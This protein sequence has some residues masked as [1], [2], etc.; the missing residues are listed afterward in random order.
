MHYTFL[1]TPVFWLVSMSKHPWIL[2]LILM[3]LIMN[4]F[5]ILRYTRIVA[6]LLYLTLSRP[7]ISFVVHKLS[8]F[9][10]QPRTPHLQAAHHLLRYIK[11]KPDQGLLFSASSPYNWK[12]FVMPI[13]LLVWTHANPLLVSVYSLVILL[14]PEK[15]RSRQRCLALQLKP[16]T[17]PLLPQQ[18]K[19][20]GL[21]SCS[22]ISRFPL[23]L[24]TP[25]IVNNQAVVHIASNPIFHERTKHIEIDCHFVRDKMQY[26]LLKLLSIR[27]HLQLADMFTKPCPLPA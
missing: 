13:G 1:M 24:R 4:H 21:P 7:D 3:I 23:M 20:C 26:E 16:S 10:S 15:P 5:Q 8:Q 12:P 17:A 9:V 25:F 22:R 19:L 11:G 18:V 27:S 14:S 2:K 6:R